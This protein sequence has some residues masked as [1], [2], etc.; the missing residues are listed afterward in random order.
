MRAPRRSSP[1]GTPK[2]Q[3]SNVDVDPYFRWALG[4]G[5]PNFFLPGRQQKWFPVVVKLTGATPRQFAQGFFDKDKEPYLHSLWGKTVR[6]PEAYTQGRSA[7]EPDSYCAAM[8]TENFQD[9]LL[10]RPEV[11]E[12]IESVQL[13]LPLD[14][15]S[16]PD[17]WFN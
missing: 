5:K 6:V 7:D 2:T 17:D 16:L 13:G 3:A 14:K 10:E 4:V 15:E 11:K 9:V 12:K 8:V 1:A